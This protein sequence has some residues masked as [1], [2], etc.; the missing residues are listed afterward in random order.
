MKTPKNTKT[1]KNL[2]NTKKSKAKQKAPAILYIEARHKKIPDNEYFIDPNFISRL[3]KDIFLCYSIQFKGQAEA[4]KRALERAGVN[5]KGFQQVLGCT[6]LKTPYTIVLIGQGSFHALNLASQNTR[7]VLL[8]SNGSSIA[9]TREEIEKK[10]KV[11]LNKFYTYNKL[12]I[13]VSTKPGQN[14]IEDA[15]MLKEK[16]SLKYPEKQVFLFIS[17]NINMHELENFQIDLWINSAC[18][19]ILN[20]SNKIANIDDIFEALEASN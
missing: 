20:D 15:M 11:A 2:K 17:N 3:P 8:Y 18:P 12:G 1:A 16:I 9:V 6:K 7:P 5:V 13:I 10:K 19:G 14:R 4:M